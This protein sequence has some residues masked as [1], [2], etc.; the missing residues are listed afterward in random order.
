VLQ[1]VADLSP[2]AIFLSGSLA[3]SFA[4]LH[5][6][7]ARRLRTSLHEAIGPGLGNAVVI[8]PVI[9]AGS[10]HGSRASLCGQGNSF[11]HKEAPDGAGASELS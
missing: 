6:T 1:A 4:L 11:R 5:R 7:F 10:H 8:E 9:S 2:A 3:S